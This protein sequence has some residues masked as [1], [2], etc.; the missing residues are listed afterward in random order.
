MRDR[1]SL[2]LD[3]VDAQRGRV[4]QD[5]GQVVVEEVD[6]VDVKDAPVRLGQQPGLE[7]PLALLQRPGDVSSARPRTAVDLPVPLG[8]LI[9]TP[10]TAGLTALIRSA[11]F[12]RS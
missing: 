8:P 7:R 9:S 2:P 3:H 5:V 1:D 6:L 11:F 10:P 12:R 4:E